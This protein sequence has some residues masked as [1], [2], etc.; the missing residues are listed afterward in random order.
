M[1]TR[2]YK[3]L[4]NT[5][6]L[7]SAQLQSKP[8]RGAKSHN[9]LIIMTLTNRQ[10]LI[11]DYIDQVLDNMSTKDLV[12]IVADQLEENLAQY[13]D[14]ELINEITEYYPELLED[15]DA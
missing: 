10:Q 8:L 1:E 3:L 2:A 9:H 7:D 13:S 14:E 15:S 11:D 5:R 4:V 12:L 6:T